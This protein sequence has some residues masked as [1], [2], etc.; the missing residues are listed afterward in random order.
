M[1][2]YTSD[3]TWYAPLVNATGKTGCTIPADGA[4]HPVTLDLMQT[5]RFGNVCGITY[6]RAMFTNLR[7][8]RFCFAG[9][10]GDTV[11]IDSIR[12]TPDGS[13][14]AKRQFAAHFDRAATP[15]DW[16]SAFFVQILS[17]FTK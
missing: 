8:L 3:T 4:W 17:W 10:A 7:H 5:Y 9:E 15:F 13:E 11:Q 6:T 12:F 1:R 2:L 16:F 14:T